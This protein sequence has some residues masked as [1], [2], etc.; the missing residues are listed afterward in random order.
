M[1]APTL[2]ARATARRQRRALV[3]L[4][5]VLA[6]GL[7]VAL[8]VL[9]VAARTDRAYDHYLRQ[10]EVGDVVVNPALS[11]ERAAEIIEATPGVRSVTSDDLLTATLDQGAARTQSEV[12][13]NYVQVRVSNDGRYT[14]QDRPTILEGR[15][16]HGGA[17][18]LVSREAADAYD[19]AVGDRLPI[20][21]WRPSY[22]TPGVGAAQDELVEPLGRETTTVVGVAVFADEV[23]AEPLY[24]RTV[25]LVTPEVGGPYTCVIGDL[26]TADVRTL[27][28]LVTV[29]PRDCSLSYRYFSIA[30]DGGA[31]QATAVTDR[32][33]TVFNEENERL[34]TVAREADV[35][36]SVLS[37]FTDD[38]RDAMTRALAPGVTA[39]RAFG[40]AAAAA[41]VVLV[42]LVAFRVAR[43]ARVDQLVWRQLG[44]CRAG[45]T[46]ALT[47][48]L[49]GAVLAGVTGALV[50]GWL[51]SAR[52]AVGS[53]AIVEPGRAPHL[54]LDVTAIVLVVV[55]GALTAGVLAIGA[56]ITAPPAPD[57]SPRRV[58]FLGLGRRLPPASDLGVR[59]AT[60]GASALALVLGGIVAVSAVA[61]T[62]VFTANLNALLDQ[63]SRY[64]WT[65]D[66][67]VLLGFGYGGSD[68]EVIAEALDRDDV[69]H[70]GLAALPAVTIQGRTVAAVAARRGYDGLDTPVV[71][72]RY[73]TAVDE[74]A[75]GR[76][77]AEDL[78]V[79]IGDEVDVSSYLGERR[80]TIS[81]V[82]V[83]PAV[84]AYQSNRAESGR[85]ALLSAPF[86][87]QALVDAE[88]AAGMEPGSLEAT[89]MSSLVAVDLADGVDP[90]EFLAD[91]G[92][93]RRWDRNGFESLA[94][95]GPVRP[96]ALEEAAA[97][98]GVP[99]ALGGLLAAAMVGGLALGI[100][101]ATNGRRRE[102]ALLRAL[103]CSARDLRRSV[104]WHALSV[105]AISVVVGLPLGVAIGRT[106]TR[107]FLADL[108]VDDSMVVPVGALIVVAGV[109]ALA[110]LLASVG[111]ARTASTPTSTGSTVS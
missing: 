35:G 101:I 75:V 41:T 110:A 56:S 109:A 84:G 61:T 100:A 5:A 91:L 42:L 10:A 15:M 102:L 81:G 93:R 106:A 39:L 27:E 64:G 98:R 63:P 18:A 23:L 46:V 70:W 88:S 49:G 96:P 38:Q 31:E 57:R 97:L 85:G 19:L 73:P 9:A 82:V 36:Y 20:A 92:D 53:A 65:Y 79:Q 6:I 59:A 74:I 94:V 71:Q 7:G 58:L 37:T 69:D 76:Q 51:G 77:T 34:P 66:A 21:F 17:E 1:G 12:D 29:V 45:R 30:V 50:V 60:T 13:S 3:G 90:D 67:A 4:T 40:S 83:L 22:N 86:F 99:L 72:G 24:P 108:G 14:A 95:S 32:M 103:G 52:G 11:T 44:V 47:V 26:A 105:A 8:A 48:P 111:P 54:P 107:V 2:L 16:V 89:G 55:M 28:D 104:R 68:D 62:A 78:D 80:A 43:R 33:T 25:V 87:A